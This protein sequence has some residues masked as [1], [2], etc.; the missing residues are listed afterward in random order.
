MPKGQ[1]VQL[2][3][4]G[5]YSIGD[6]IPKG[7]F[8]AGGR[9]LGS[10]FGPLGSKAGGYLGDLLSRITGVGDYQVSGSSTG[11]V[12]LSPQPTTFNTGPAKTTLRHR[13]FIAN[14]V[15]SSTPGA[16]KI[17]SYPINIGIPGSFPWGSGVAANWREHCFKGCV[18]EYRSTSGVLGTAGTSALGSVVM[19][20]QYNSYDAPFASKVAMEVTDMAGSC[21]PSVSMLHGIEC[22]KAQNPLCEMYIR[23]GVSTP[24]GDLRMYDLG[25]FSI[26]TSG[27]PN[28]S[29]Q[30][31]E[32]WVTYD[33]DLFKTSLGLDSFGPQFL[34]SSAPAATTN[35]GAPSWG[36]GLVPTAS[37]GD[38]TLVSQTATTLT[39]AVGAAG[40]YVQNSFLRTA[41]NDGPTAGFGVPAAVTYTSA[42]PGFVPIAATSQLSAQPSALTFPGLIA[43]YGAFY[44]P[45]P[46]QVTATMSSP[47]QAMFASV[48]TL[49]VAVTRLGRVN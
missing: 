29:Q 19:A 11:L 49:D 47:M 43:A 33:V 24:A 36:A 40:T 26:A 4:S 44:L 9:A 13:E 25:R 7:S 15:T 39:W 23:D 10:I 35:S 46:G 21:A 27:N 17:D 2:R 14:V 48:T 32:L 18:F 34:E 45:A 5:A 1:M 3:G 37:A 42:V 31:G 16:F 6:L 20:T 12:N 28:A 41:I 30:V 22:D 38:I 8:K